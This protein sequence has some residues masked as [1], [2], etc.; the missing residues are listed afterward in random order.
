MRQLIVIAL[1]LLLLHHP[2]AVAS[3]YATAVTGSSSGATDIAPIAQI[4][5]IAP[6]PANHQRDQ[7]FLSGSGTVAPGSERS[8]I[9]YRWLL[10]SQQELGQ[11]PL[12]AVP[13]ASLAVGTHT[14]SLIVQDNTGRWSTPVTRTL[15]IVAD[16]LLQVEP[17][18]LHALI[19]SGDRT[20][21]TITVTNTGGSPLSVSLQI[22]PTSSP[23]TIVQAA[24]ALTLPRLITTPT[25]SSNLRTVPAGTVS[26]ER[27]E[28]YLI[29]L[30]TVADLRPAT[31]IA[32]W[33]AR[34]RFVVQRLKEVADASQADL[35][36][37]LEQQR[38]NGTVLTYR[39]FY[40]LNAIAV[41]GT[42]EA[43]RGLLGRPQVMAVA[44]SEVFALPGTNE[45]SY[46]SAR[47]TGMGIPWHIARIGV[48]RVWGELGI[49]GDGVVVGSIDTGVALSHPLLQANYRG[50]QPDG[51]YD[52]SYSWFDPTGTY[53]GSPG[54]SEGHGTHTLGSM[55]G[56]GGIGVA[57]GAHWIAARGCAG[58]SCRDIDLLAAMEWMLAPYPST[59]GPAGANPDMRPQIIN[60][61]WG[62]PGSTPLFQQMLSVWRAA[63]IF[64]AFAAGNCGVDVT[65]C[66]RSG[67]SS[68]HS[69]A[70]Y[71]ESFTTGAAGPN[72]LLAPFS[73]RGPSLLTS[74]IKPDLVAP[75][76][77]IE[78]TW[79]NGETLQLNG[80]SMASPLTAGVAALL[81]AARPG[82]GVDQ[83]EDL[84][85]TTATDAGPPGADPEY[86]Y[87]L[88]NGY[89]A[90][91]AAR[92]GLAW[93]RL[94]QSNLFIQAGQTVTM[95]VVFDGRALRVGN[96]QA[97]LM[98]RSN[99]PTHPE[100]A[101]PLQFTIYAAMSR[102]PVLISH[103]TASGVLVRWDAPDGQVAHLAYAT[104]PAG[105]WVE[106]PGN[107]GN[108]PGETIIVMR[109][110]SA[111]TTYYLQL[112]AADG[113]ME[114][115]QGLLYHVTTGAPPFDGA[116]DPSGYR[117]YLPIV[118]H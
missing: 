60:N 72:D 5:S 95:T 7:L 65:G 113:T 68:L 40:S 2:I 15:E 115:N 22:E 104:N 70:D 31:T 84:L 14:V 1:Y 53:P 118:A 37:Y 96:Y 56:A 99:D 91:Q 29:Y 74:M 85:R 36:R 97:R 63:G 54:D 39:P 8:I 35:I 30:N 69:P 108:T 19:A 48:D 81:L 42:V 105:P 33:R 94:P 28:Q 73:S 32:D 45:P 61:S 116:T 23:A 87:G 83:I 98:V 18:T 79:I 67:A 89:A 3:P 101:I 78:S 50:L 58:R 52:H 59:A 6:N 107:P 26:S 71:A 66:V 80:T 100:V 77:A 11:E 13:A 86:G 9:G 64:P 111:R 27:Y 21:R 34:G 17:L 117:L 25:L 76:M 43:V 51:S 109:G 12:L 47:T 38:Q 93:V 44:V 82:L 55:V 20:E 92:Q 41:T 110:L 103:V 46:P 62:S 75:G 49:R 88:L 106:V 16:P 112:I 10:N 57:P 102:R 114:D 24:H 4:D 90:V